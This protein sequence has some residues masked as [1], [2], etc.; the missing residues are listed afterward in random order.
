MNCAASVFHSADLQIS[1]E[2][3]FQEFF[4]RKGRVEMWRGSIRAGLSV[5]ASFVWRC[6]SNLAIAPFPHP[7]IKPDVQIS[8]IRLSCTRSPQQHSGYAPVSEKK[9]PP[10]SRHRISA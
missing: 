4:T 10:A 7:L 6:P 1:I 2:S 9:L 8:R 5:A 3:H